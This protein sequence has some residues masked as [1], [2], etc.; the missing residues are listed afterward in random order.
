M[1]DVSGWELQ[2]ADVEQMYVK[3]DFRIVKT[4][5]AYSRSC[6]EA[7][8]GN[9]RLTLKFDLRDTMDYCD[10][11]MARMALTV[12]EP[13]CRE[14]EMYNEHLSAT[15]LLQL[16]D[17]VSD[18]YAIFIGAEQSDDLSITNERPHRISLKY[19]EIIV[20]V[21][22][23]C[24]DVQAGGSSPKTYDDG[25]LWELLQDRLLKDKFLERGSAGWQDS[26][27][28]AVPKVELGIES[29]IEK[30]L[31]QCQGRIGKVG[32]KG[33]SASPGVFREL[34]GDD[35]LWLE[36]TS[37]DL[38]KAIRRLESRGFVEVLYVRSQGLPPEYTLRWLK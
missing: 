2:E 25:K 3:G 17:L 7:F 14:V 32:V 28:A 12:A 20:D 16:N 21:Y 11:L 33:S 29:A 34:D 31:I 26:V 23:G 1:N 35:C 10:S 4:K 24:V 18:I 38:E 9:I 5:D 36:C 37:T 13:Q 22:E 15:E 6:W 27:N 30:Y 8:Q 19:G